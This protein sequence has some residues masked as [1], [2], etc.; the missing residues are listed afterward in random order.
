MPHNRVVNGF[1]GV[2]A[3]VAPAARLDSAGRMPRMCGG[4]GRPK[5]VQSVR[6]RVSPGAACFVLAF[7]G[8]AL[9]CHPGLAG[10]DSGELTTAAFSLGIPHP[11][12]YPLWLILARTW[13]WVFPVGEVAF[14]LNVLSGL[15]TAGAV[16][17]L[18]RLHLR[19]GR[20]PLAAA[21]LALAFAWSPSVWGQSLA[22][23]VYPLQL[24]LG[25]LYLLA[26]VRWAQD[27]DPAWLLFAAL[28]AGA[29]L[30]HHLTS[31][32]VIAAGGLVVLPRLRSIPWRTA[33]WQLALLAALPLVLF[34][35]LV[36]RSSANPPIDWGN[37]E[38]LTALY[39]HVT[40]RQYG[41]KLLPVYAGEVAVNAAFV[42]KLLRANF[43]LL[44]MIP[45]AAGLILGVTGGRAWGG[46]FAALALVQGVFCLLYR[47]QDPE[48]FCLPLLL[49][50]N[51]GLG[52]AFARLEP[53]WQSRIPPR[54]RAAAGALLAAGLLWFGVSTAQRV[55]QGP[56]FLASSYASDILDSLPYGAT[57]LSSGDFRNHTLLYTQV[58][59]QRRTDVG[60]LASKGE[61]FQGYR[62]A[63]ERA[64]GRLFA[65]EAVALPGY[66]LAPYG[67]LLAPAQPGAPLP[68]P[69]ERYRPLPT[70]AQLRRLGERDVLAQYIL[71]NRL[72]ARWTEAFMARDD[73]EAGRLAP[74]LLAQGERFMKLITP[75]V[76][77]SRFMVGLATRFERWDRLIAWGE[78]LGAVEP[79]AGDD[80][81]NVAWA[82]LQTGTRLQEA[83]RLARLASGRAPSNPVYLDTL[84]QI[85][86]AAGKRQ[87]A[88]DTMRR[89]LA[90]APDD[91]EIRRDA[92]KLLREA[93]G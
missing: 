46:A 66:R 21:G 90:L 40:G 76:D 15:C 39:R 61:L 17:A 67:I 63:L 62:S 86:L 78:R 13:L 92:A 3:I 16:A 12:G 28:L 81:N 71:F 8:Y 49:A 11:T 58:V 52:E 70:E 91:P 4:P 88:V 25:G 14:R 31:V 85:L 51:L 75:R 80:A 41:S 45:A 29:Q 34:A 77:E 84:A 64:P 5:G 55:G 60:V 47:V 37:P 24:L 38:T 69:W 26:L 50:L 72:Q 43:P 74:E 87:E 22:A 56:T 30:A 42:G 93:G 73:A 53:H 6:V 54:A 7:A 82:Y 33:G 19:L 68:D 65:D 2:K 44:T 35:L 9:T 57:L 27:D 20:G 79:L 32:F 10:G 59:E 83:E 1:R 18:C 48:P 36:V 89:A 23:E